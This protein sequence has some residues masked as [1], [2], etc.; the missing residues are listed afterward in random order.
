LNG[1]SCYNFYGESYIQSRDET[2]F[3]DNNSILFKEIKK[4]D[5]FV[6]IYGI[7]TGLEYKKNINEKINFFGKLFFGYGFIDFDLKRNLEFIVAGDS[8]LSGN[9]IIEYS[10]KYKKGCFIGDLSIGSEYNFTENFG[11]GFDVGY[12]LSSK[13]RVAQYYDIF[14]EKEDLELDFSGFN[15]NLSFKYKI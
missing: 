10:K 7:M 3:I 6:N 9:Y 13:V 8:F 12:R 14:D 1:K 2:G 15:T 5:Y 4:Y 11:V